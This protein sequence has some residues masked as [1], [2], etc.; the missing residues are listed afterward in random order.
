MY[1]C[2]V[3]GCLLI[4]ATAPGKSLAQNLVRY[5]ANQPA[6]AGRDTANVNSQAIADLVSKVSASGGGKVELPSG[7][8]YVAPLRPFIEASCRRF[9]LAKVNNSGNR[10]IEKFDWLKRVDLVGQRTTLRFYTGASGPMLDL[11]DHVAFFDASIR[12]ITF[13]GGNHNIKGNCDFLLGFNSG[14]RHYRCVIEDCNFVKNQRGD[15]LL[16]G[17][18]QQVSVINVACFDNSGWGMVF[19]DAYAM[20]IQMADCERNG[21][22]GILIKSPKR[23]VRVSPHLLFNSPYFEQP[24]DTEGIVFD[25]CQNVRVNNAT[26]H[27]Y[28]F[29]NNARGNVVE[30]PR[31]YDPGD[32]TEAVFESGAIGNQVIGLN[33]LRSGSAAEDNL[34]PQHREP[35]RR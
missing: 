17:G 26:V 27:R 11:R 1:R 28:R 16:C 3:L 10:S 22:G 6:T 2:V 33:V 12:N 13:D 31:R 15:G 21:I 35:S 30:D 9:G 19:D 7:V 20:Y 18:G 25:G 14:A 34:L 24:K 29:R 32:P 5:D 8:F 23:G 4:Q